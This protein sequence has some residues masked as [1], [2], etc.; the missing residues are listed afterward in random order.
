MGRQTG[1]QSQLTE[2][3]ASQVSLQPRAWKG[4]LRALLQL[5]LMVSEK[6][7]ARGGQANRRDQ[8]QQA[9][10]PGHAFHLLAEQ[11]GPSSK[12]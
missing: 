3:R 5:L 10:R 11:V 6:K 1:D 8:Q 2:R 7:D 12:Q 9:D 4:C